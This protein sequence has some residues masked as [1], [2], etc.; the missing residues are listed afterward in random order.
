MPALSPAGRKKLLLQLGVAGLLAAAV[1]LFLLKGMHIFALIDQV[2]AIVSG[3]G[4]WIF[5]SAFAVLP[6]LGAP[7]LGFTLLAGSAFAGRMGMSGVVLAGMAAT[8]FNLTLSYCLAR[9]II[10]KWVAQLLERLGY[11]M[12]QVAE[13]DSTDLIVILRVTP[14]V[15]FVVQNYLL[16]LADAPAGRYFLLSCLISLPQCA[17][18]IVFGNAL[19][20][21]RGAAI[22]V[23]VSLLV[24]LAAGTQLLRRHYGRRKALA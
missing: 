23:G 14:G 21:G 19:L 6:A 5:F 4:P 8:A 20:H 12:P 7:T 24:V 22:V 2:V 9:W 3:L 11:R 10:R 15:P 18:F 16:G 13:A 17:A 1:G